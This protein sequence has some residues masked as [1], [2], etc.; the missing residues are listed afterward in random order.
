MTSMMMLVVV[1]LGATYASASVL[2]DQEPRE[3]R[4]RHARVSNAPLNS[5]SPLRLLGW[6]AL[7][8]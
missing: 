6:L 7:Q 4:G 5:S 3:H 2:E 1:V 8:S